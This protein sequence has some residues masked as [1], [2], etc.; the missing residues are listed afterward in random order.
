MIIMVRGTSGSGK[1][2]VA[3]QVL[4]RLGNV[5][6]HLKIG[7]KS[8]LGGYL[9]D[10]VAVVGKYETACGGCDAYSW[11]GAAEDIKDLVLEHASNRHVL[12]EGLM[13]SG[14]GIERVLELNSQSCGLTVVHLMTPLEECLESVRERR[15][16]R[17]ESLGREPSELNTHN[18][19]RK[20]GELLRVS[21]KQERAGVRVEYLSRSEA[22]SRVLEL[23]EIP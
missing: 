19:T 10:R 1:T 13:V 8:T 6:S 20:H 14:W 5:Y 16:K 18:T 23:L 17:A 21:Q 22:L 4:S 3:Q 15:R 12:L 2:Y 7:P 11:R 9:F